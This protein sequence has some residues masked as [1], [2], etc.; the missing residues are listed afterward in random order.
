MHEISFRGVCNRNSMDFKIATKAYKKYGESHIDRLDTNSINA[1]PTQRINVLF[2][3]IIACLPSNITQEN[4]AKWPKNLKYLT[5]FN[6][7]RGI[8]LQFF[9][10]LKAAM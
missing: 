9:L 7:C 1:K 2:L 5:Y 4:P 10:A 6:N 3:Q 8:F